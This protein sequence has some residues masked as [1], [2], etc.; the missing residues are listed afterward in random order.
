MR[1]ANKAMFSTNI[2]MPRAEGILASLSRCKYFSK[3]DF[4]SASHHI[5]IAEES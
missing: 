3:L 5:E 1:E 2:P 4:K